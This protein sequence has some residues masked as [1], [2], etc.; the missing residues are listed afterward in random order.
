MVRVPP[1]LVALVPVLVPA[2]CDEHAL[3]PAA[4]RAAAHTQA[5]TDLRLDIFVMVVL[6]F[7]AGPAADAAPR[8]ESGSGSR[9][10]G[11]GRRGGRSLRGGTLRTTRP[12]TGG[13]PCGPARRGSRNCGGSRAR[14]AGRPRPAAWPCCGFGRAGSGPPPRRVR[15]SA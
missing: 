4:S 8:R 5:A 13:R 12:L 2:E 9:P 3:A 15:A 14:S 10:E 1:P 11:L 7:C 6:L